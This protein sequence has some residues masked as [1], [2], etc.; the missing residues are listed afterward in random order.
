MTDAVKL[1]DLKYPNL[2]GDGSRRSET[3]RHKGRPRQTRAARA[4]ASASSPRETESPLV[5][6]SLSGLAAASQQPC[7]LD[8][9]YR[10]LAEV[11]PQNHPRT[12]RLL[13]SS[14]RKTAQKL[15]EEAGEVALEAV[16]HHARGV[17]RESADLLYHL[18]ALWHR[19]GID[20]DD[21]WTE[22]RCRADTLGI[23]EKGPKARSDHVAVQSRTS[24]R[25]PKLNRNRP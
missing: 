19:A 14:S 10:S 5:P 12:A 9:L 11:T 24:S 23:A 25:Q 21:V 17:V 13:A 7:E 6:D 16:K 3:S 15:I 20:P 1:S 18:V 2:Q 4:Q 22:M 8:R